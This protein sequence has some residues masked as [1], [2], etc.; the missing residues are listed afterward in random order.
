[1]GAHPGGRVPGAPPCTWTFLSSLGESGYFSNLL[2][3]WGLRLGTGWCG[4]VA[5]SGLFPPSTASSRLFLLMKTVA[6]LLD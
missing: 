6:A 3:W 1:M 2:G 4:G 5:A